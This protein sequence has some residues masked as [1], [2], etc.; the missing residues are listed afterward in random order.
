MFSSLIVARMDPGHA[1][2]VA[3]IF[4]RFDATDMPA[5]MGTLRRELFRYRG[6]YF[7]L[8][9]FE[10]PDGTGAVEAAKSDPR[11]IGI[12]NDLR[13]YIDAYAPDWRSPKDAMAERFYHWQA[14]R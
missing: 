13:P 10:T 4:T 8:Q 5:R 1:G 14:E 11:F 9:D 6:L 7:H 3:D 2:A 12:S